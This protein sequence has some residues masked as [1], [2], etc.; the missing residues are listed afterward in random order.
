MSIDK[1]I[2]Q[3]ICGDCL[4]VLKQIPDKCVDLCL[5]DFPYGVNYEYDQ[6]ED[7]EKN[8][9]Q[10]V[11]KAMPEI[12]RISKRTLIT[13][14][15]KNLFLYPKPD[16]IL[17]WISTAGAG[18]NPWGFSCWQPIVAYGKDPY[19]ENKKGS[20]PDIIMSNETSVNFGHSCTKPINLW[21]KI[22]LSGSVKETDIILD[23]FLGSGTT[24]VAAKQLGRR[25]IGVDISEDY[26]NISRQRLAQETIFSYNKVYEKV[27]NKS[28]ENLHLL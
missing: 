24:A 4:E 20:M 7:T 27:D 14:G 5:T 13:T 6:Y 15:I 1:Y 26:C 16:W 11:K 8:L 10:L 9:I 2:N 19:L 17:S 12:L 18:C 3:V 21:K 28:K 22:L 25:F 23:P